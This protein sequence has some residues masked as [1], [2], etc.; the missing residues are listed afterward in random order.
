MLPSSVVTHMTMKDKILILLFLNL[1]SLTIAK[2]ERIRESKESASHVVVGEV[3]KVF[4]SDGKDYVGYVVR[5]KVEMFE[6]GTGPAKGHH[7][8][9]ECFERKPHEGPGRPAP[10]ASGHSGVPKVGERVRIFTNES[11]AINLGVYPTWYDVLPSV[12]K[13]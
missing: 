1:F 10:G 4:K 6:K 5:I 9:V 13:E 11:N 7:F 12:D 3:T 2:G 8:Y